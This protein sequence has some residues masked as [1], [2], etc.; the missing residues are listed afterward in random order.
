SVVARHPLGRFGTQCGVREPAE[1]AESIVDRDKYDPALRISAAVIE[2][3]RACA[4]E[5]RA[6][7]N[8]DDHRRLRRRLRCPDVERQT[9]LAH[10][11]RWF[12]IDTVV[13]ISGLDARR[14]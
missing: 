14:A 6:A 12:E 9:I 1:D 8:P 2:R 4:A 5:Q 13:G 7:M 3:A 11:R 10:R